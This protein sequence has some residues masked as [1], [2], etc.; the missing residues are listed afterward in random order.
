MSLGAIYRQFAK[1]SGLLGSLAGW[2]MATRSSNVERNRWTVELLDI[3]PTDR[4]LEIGFGPGLALAGIVRRLGE[5]CVVG[6][7]HSD[8]ML[9]QARKRNEAAIAS[10]RLR[11]VQGGMEKLPALRAPFDKVLSVNV[12]QF[13]RDQDRD[14]VLKSIGSIMQ[15]GGLLATTY[16]P[17]HRAATPEDATAF[18]A[19]FTEALRRAGFCEVHT[20]RLELRPIPVVC[21]LARYP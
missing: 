6:I 16:Q 7:D 3:Q 17:R 19:A 12:M 8:V 20:R 10:G 4:V 14:G 18:A 21:V 1:P 15:T 9:S 2:I 13:I 5:G 11:L